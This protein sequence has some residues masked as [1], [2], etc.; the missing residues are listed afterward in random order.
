VVQVD[1]APNSIQRIPIPAVQF[2]PNIQLFNSA[3]TL[4][5]TVDSDSTLGLLSE[6][7][8]I[9]FIQDYETREDALTR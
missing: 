6:N 4:V 9:T 3:G 7:N 8:V 1:G 2:N 5:R